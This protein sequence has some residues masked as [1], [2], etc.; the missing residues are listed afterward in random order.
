MST[1]DIAE[2]SLHNGSFLESAPSRSMPARKL[3]KEQWDFHREI[4]ESM[5][6]MKGTTIGNIV[7]TLKTRG[8]VVT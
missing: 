4:I 8:F 3:P 2:F 7:S 5:Y 1:S 6:P